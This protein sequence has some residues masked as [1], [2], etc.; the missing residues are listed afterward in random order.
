MHLHGKGVGR[1]EKLQQQRITIG[2]RR[3]LA[4]EFALE[5]FAEFVECLAGQR[6][7]DDDALISGEPRLAD[8]F[9]AFTRERRI[10]WREI[11]RA[12]GTRAKKWLQEKWV[13]CH[14]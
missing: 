12:P 2:L 11:A 13:K 1:E 8:G 10:D 3:R 4:D 7:V 5:L 14:L 6:P 9:A